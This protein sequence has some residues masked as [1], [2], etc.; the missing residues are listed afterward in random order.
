MV[1]PDIKAI[2][3]AGKSFFVSEEELLKLEESSSIKSFSKAIEERVIL[4]FDNK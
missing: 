1:D 3:T 2:P 4:N